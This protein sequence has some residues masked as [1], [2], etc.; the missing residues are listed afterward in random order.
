MISF[1]LYDNYSTKFVL[2]F[3]KLVENSRNI[4][5]TGHE[6]ADDDTLASAILIYGLLTSKFKNK[7]IRMIFSGT[8][9]D[10]LNIF[11]DYG[12]IKFVK[13]LSS[14]VSGTD[15]LIMLDGGN[16]DRFS[17]FPEKLKTIPSTICID[18]HS[19][20]P[21][22]FS[23]SMVMPKEPACTQMI[24]RTFFEEKNIDKKT[25]EIILWGILG[26]TGTFAYLKKNQTGTLAIAKKLLEISGIEIQE[27][28]SKYSSISKKIFDVIQELT[29]NT[30]FVSVSGWPPF[31]YSFIEKDYV[32]KYNLTEAEIN[33]AGFYYSSTYIRNITGFTW[34]FVVTPK[35]DGDVNISCR[36][37]IGSVNVR[38]LMERMGV[39]GGHDRASGGTF[40]KNGTDFDVDVCIEK[41]LK[42]I[43]SHRPVLA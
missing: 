41:T 33:D 42:W 29:K 40:R 32:K 9:D 28:Q 37:L 19:S 8:S 22:K 21:D 34:G 26:D 20:R 3:F 18:H 36:S 14:F 5:I 16:Y 4:I 24:Y 2:D 7:D 39:G 31:Q 12:K 38:D 15:L 11:R 30:K 6:S 1:V 10:R 23:L 13:D 17:H 25:A 43:K 27:F 35:E